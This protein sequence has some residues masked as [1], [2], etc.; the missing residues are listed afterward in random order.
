MNVLTMNKI[1][2]L[3]V[4]ILLMS[5]PARAQELLVNVSVDASRI[6]SDRSVFEDMQQAISRYLNLQQWT[7]DKYEG[8]ERIRANLQIVVMQRPGPDQFVCQA[9]LQV[10]RPVFNTTYET[11]SLNLS[12]KKF[13]FT[14]VQF[15]PLQ[16][17][18]N[19]Y[20][21]NLTALLNFYAYIILGIDYD[22]FAPNGGTP[23]FQ[24][25]QEIAN[26]AASSAAESGWRASEDNRNRYWL[27]ENLM[28]SRYRMFHDAMYKYHR[29]GLDMMESSPA[30]GRRAITAALK[31]MQRVHQQNPILRITRVFLD[32]KQ[33]ELV[34]AYQQAFVNDKQEFL[35]IMQ[36]L[37]PSNMPSY[38]AVM[39]SN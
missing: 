12:D 6:Q 37:D 34:K 25:A 36:E 38:N 16:F 15:Q 32:A 35:Q 5:V 1:L 19:T 9:N 24:K 10:Y 7:K 23:Y 27:V 28:N 18:E 17:I 31:D 13:N 29:Q 8:L 20:T 3:I 33:D 11:M 21:D 22:T 2:A 26:L 14:Y 4:G 30:Q 39:D